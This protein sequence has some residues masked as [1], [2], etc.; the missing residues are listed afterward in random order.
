MTWYEA[1]NGCRNFLKSLWD[2]K[3]KLLIFTCKP[4]K[5]DQENIIVRRDGCINS[6]EKSW[7][8][9]EKHIISSGY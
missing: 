3:V 1:G 4:R 9:E 2:A 7:F 6:G 8:E 5:Q